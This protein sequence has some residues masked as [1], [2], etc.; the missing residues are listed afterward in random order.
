VERFPEVEGDTDSERY[1]HL[2][3]NNLDESHPVA[4]IDRALSSLKNY[5]SLNAFLLNENRFYA[6]NR[7]SKSP[8]YYT[9]HLHQGEE[10]ALLSSEPLLDVALDWNPLTNGTVVIFD[11]DAGTVHSLASPTG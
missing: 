1:F 3:L 8:L 10:G 2:L 7:F 9:L 11:R 4:S 6:I 5:T